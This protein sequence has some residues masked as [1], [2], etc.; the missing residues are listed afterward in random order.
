MLEVN[1]IFVQFHC[2]S[3]NRNDAVSKRP[4]TSIPLLGRIL[5][6]QHEQTNL[7]GQGSSEQGF[8]VVWLES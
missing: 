2:L 4:V 1:E 3:L 7:F 6:H 5:K 8:H